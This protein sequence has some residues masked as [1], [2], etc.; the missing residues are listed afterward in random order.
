VDGIYD[1]GGKQGLGHVRPLTDEPPFAAPSESRTLGL[2]LARNETG[3]IEW[4]D[5]RQAL[6]RE[7][8]G[9]AAAHPSGA[10]WSYYE[11]WPRALDRAAS[12]K[13]LADPG[14]LAERGP[15]LAARP[16]GYGQERHGHDGHEHNMHDGSPGDP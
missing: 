6:I 16:A 2:A 7:V 11:C 13:G 9:W 15:L 8:G 12:A 10:D 14:A 4:A 5:F 3:L 1:M